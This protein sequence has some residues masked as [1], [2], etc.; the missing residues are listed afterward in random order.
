MVGGSLSKGLLVKLDR[1]QP[2]EELAVGRYIVVRSK[3]DMRFFCMVT[4]ITL[5][6]SNPGIQNHPPDM[7]DPFLRAVYIGTAAYGTVNAAPMLAIE[8]GQVKPVKTIPSHFMPVYNATVADV[9]AVFGQEDEGH[10]NIG[11]PLEL[12]TT[13]INLDLQR[14]AERSVG[15]FGKSGTGKSFLT[16]MLIAG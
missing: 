1:Q 7:D 3:D 12:E 15:V 10:F 8:A 16:R 9:N 11:S 13:R 14:L 4:D 5:N 6:S 2:V